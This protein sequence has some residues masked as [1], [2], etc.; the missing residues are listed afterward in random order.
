[1]VWLSG[2]SRTGETPSQLLR[3]SGKA[4]HPFSGGAA[5]RLEPVFGGV[6]A[7]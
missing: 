6:A 2:S 5:V 1:M 4:M 3:N 7:V